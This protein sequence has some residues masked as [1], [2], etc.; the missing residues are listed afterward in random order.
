MQSVKITVECIGCKKR[1]DIDYAESQRLSLQGDVPLCEDCGM[2]AIAI[3][4]NILKSPP[5]RK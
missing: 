5:R 2:P 3:V 4:A 1:R